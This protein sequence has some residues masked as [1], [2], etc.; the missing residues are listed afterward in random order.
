MGFFLELPFTL[1][2]RI[3]LGEA[4]RMMGLL[5]ALYRAVLKLQSS[6]QVHS[7]KLLVQVPQGIICVCCGQFRV[8]IQDTETGKRDARI[9]V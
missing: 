6:H 2:S 1:F 7:S 3:L 9:C 4:A 5:P 8:E